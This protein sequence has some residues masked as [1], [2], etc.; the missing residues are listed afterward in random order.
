MEVRGHGEVNPW[1]GTRGDSRDGL[2]AVQ[3]TATGIDRR[4]GP[5]DRAGG[6]NFRDACYRRVGAV[7]AG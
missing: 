3:H 5:G 1:A 2:F 7:A 6:R 4:R